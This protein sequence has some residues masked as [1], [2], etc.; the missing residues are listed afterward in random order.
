MKYNVL[1]DPVLFDSG[2]LPPNLHPVKTPSQT[3]TMSDEFLRNHPNFKANLPS[4]Y[5][6]STQ[7]KFRFPQDRNFDHYIAYAKF[8]TTLLLAS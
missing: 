3:N 1:E 8:R 6:I 5:M 2:M 7:Y 4:L